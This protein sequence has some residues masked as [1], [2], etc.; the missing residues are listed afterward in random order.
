MLRRTARHTAEFAGGLLLVLLIVAA[1]GYFWL[2]RGPVALGFLSQPIESIVNAS[3]T[4]MSV[5]IK[6]VVIEQNDDAS[7]VR[8]R[9]RNLSLLDSTGGIIARAPR[10]AIGVDW[11][12]LFRG[13]VTPARLA[14]IG[15][16]LLL[17]RT[18]GGM[19]QLGYG[20]GAEIGAAGAGSGAAKTDVLGIV[21]DAL[22]GPEGKGATTG[23]K[24][25]SIREAR[26]EFFDEVNQVVWEAPSANL[27]FQRVDNGVSLLATAKVKAG[28]KEWGL[29]FSAFYGK[30]SKRIDASAR[31]SGLVPAD[32]ARKVP[33]LS[34]LAQVRLPLS[35]R[36]QLAFDREGRVL[37][38]NAMLSAGAGIVDFPGF[39]TEPIIIDSGELN[40]AFDP[41]SGDVTLDRS[42]VR[43]KGTK[44]SVFG[45][46]SPSRNAA[47]ELQTVRIKLEAK[48]IADAAGAAP[49]RRVAIDTVLLEGV[50]DL[51]DR[52]LDVESLFVAAGDARVLLTG[53]LRD[54]DKAPAIR[55]EGKLSRIP[56]DLLLALWPPAAAPGAREWYSENILKGVVSRGQIKVDI[57]SDALARALD[58]APLPNEQLRL[59]FD[60]ENV[61]TRY[62]DDMPPIRNAYGSGLVEGDRFE[63]RLERGRIAPDK[64][65][66]LT[67]SRGRFTVEN[68]SRKGP[69]S[70]LTF[71]IVGPV[72]SVLT[73]LDYEPLRFMTKFGL[74]INRVGGQSV[75]DYKLDIPLLKHLKLEQVSLKAK[76]RLSKLRVDKV[77][78]KSAIEGGELALDITKTRLVGRGRVQINGVPAK[79]SW[80]ED[81]ESK[82]KYT[83]RFGLSGTFGEDARHRLDIDVSEFVAGPV[84]VNL[85]AYGKGPDIKIADVK[86]DLTGATLKFD[87]IEWSK[88]PGRKAA[89]KFAIEFEKGG[90]NRFSRFKVTG[91]AIDVAGEFTI[92]NQGRM[93][94]V[95]LNRLNL[96]V[97]RMKL[98][99]KRR[100]DGV[101]ALKMNADLLD[102]RPMVGGLFERTGSG[103]RSS[104][105]DGNKSERI[106][107][108]AVISN[109]FGYNNVR[110]SNIST[111]M[112]LKGGDIEAMSLTGRF[113]RRGAVEVA[114]S[115]DGSGARKLSAKSSNAGE[116]LRAMDIYSKVIGGSLTLSA[117]LGARGSA[118]GEGRLKIKKFRVAGEKTLGR[119][120]RSVRKTSGARSGSNPAA[121]RDDGSTYFSSLRVPYIIRGRRVKVRN[122][123]LKGPSIGASAQGTLDTLTQRLEF[124][125]TFIPAYAINSLISNVPIVGLLLAGGKNQGLF[126]VTFAVSGT[127]SRPVFT[128]NPVSAIAPGI[129]RNLFAIG[130]GGLTPTGTTKKNNEIET[131]R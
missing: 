71:R 117:G 57:T 68:F 32:I 123:L 84:A 92:D 45:L 11:S 77:F 91:K 52:R 119:V 114:I 122:A 44:A 125:G 86:A 18:R 107:L 14:L 129:L 76:A 81:F 104:K 22:S 24:D 102:I 63:M 21:F 50:A 8:F 48:T 59:S 27:V 118:D 78:G 58:G 40:V 106:D 116:L 16:R 89:A 29:E 109:A 35:G 111:S 28:Q 121:P 113:V 96:G 25:I 41:V 49:S 36:A 3:L 127:V 15:P 120:G 4:G 55:L 31:I 33:I 9:L 69:L 37:A 93:R 124:G 101:I 12:A 38:A 62:L 65:R 100:K 1:A 85:V 110:M 39:I 97:N 105:S 99:G 30:D 128:I 60:V 79:F 64:A 61:D 66:P 130:G 47:G 80:R 72:Q 2:A 43:V 7:G 53:Y 131:Q 88:P 108:T 42:V 115:K 26:L 20:T 56:S 75:T 34:T 103:S 82:G 46:F 13:Q 112:R 95:D 73:A 90:L 67:I 19:F 17:K 87:A 74:D 6:D 98:S 126:G 5:R 70:Q 51:P 23:L 94:S 54:E 83:S 10:A